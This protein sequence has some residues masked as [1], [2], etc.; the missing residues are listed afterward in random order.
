MRD[1]KKLSDWPHKG[2]GGWNLQ[3]RRYEALAKEPTLKQIYLLIIEPFF[4]DITITVSSLIK[5]LRWVINDPT[6]IK[7]EREFARALD[8]AYFKITGESKPPLESQINPGWK[9]RKDAAK[10]YLRTG[11]KIISYTIPQIRYDVKRYLRFKNS[12]WHA[13]HFFEN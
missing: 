5:S 8:N 9:F 7:S 12:I 4:K 3:E 1:V 6:V 2:P 11:L 10:H 13:I